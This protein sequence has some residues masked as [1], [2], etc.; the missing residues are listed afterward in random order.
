MNHEGKTIRTKYFNMGLMQNKCTIINSL[1]TF[2]LENTG[3]NV[4]SH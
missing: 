2:Q 1:Y 4:L 3:Q